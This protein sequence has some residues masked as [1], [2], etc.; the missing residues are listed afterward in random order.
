MGVAFV[1]Q[2]QSCFHGDIG[3][4]AEYL[5]GMVMEVEVM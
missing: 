5:V 4:K 3:Q 1:D 2:S